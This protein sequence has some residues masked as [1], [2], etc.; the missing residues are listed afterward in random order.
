MNDRR[1]IIDDRLSAVTS[2]GSQTGSRTGSTRG[3]AKDGPGLPEINWWNRLA[4][5]NSGD[6][7]P[8]E[9][10]AIAQIGMRSTEWQ[11]LG[12]NAEPELRDSW[13]PANSMFKARPRDSDPVTPIKPDLAPRKLGR[14]G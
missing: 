4:A 3:L 6:G 14:G 12:R 10:T 9:T 7:S 13:P 1:Q 11:Q 8:A 5:G 2:R